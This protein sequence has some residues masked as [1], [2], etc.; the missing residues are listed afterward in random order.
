ME[1]SKNVPAQNDTLLARKKKKKNLFTQFFLDLKKSFTRFS[2][3]SEEFFV[4]VDNNFQNNLKKLKASWK[5]TIKNIKKSNPKYKRYKKLYTKLEKMDNQLSEIGA[6]TKDIKLKVSEVAFM[7]EH[8]MEEIDNIEDY[9]KENLGSDWKIIKNA[10]QRCKDGEISKKEFIKT[11][12]KK[13][14][15]RFVSIFIQ[16]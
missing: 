15:K 4:K 14:G 2:E 3:K 16:V 13:I 11:G 8:L 7:I 12:L 9:M 1:N 10:W 5:K 6:D